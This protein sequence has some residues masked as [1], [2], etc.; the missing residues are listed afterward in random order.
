MIT[1]STETTQS[2][3][4]AAPAVLDAR[5]VV[6]AFG[7]TQAIAEATIAVAPGEVHALVGENGS[8]KSTLV[9]ILTGVHPPDAGTVVVDG[10]TLD[11]VPGPR[12]ASRHGI[13]TAFQEV[14][15]VPAQTV[16]ENL[17]LGVDGILR[18]RVGREQKRRRGAAILAELLVEP[19]PLDRPVEELSLSVRQACCVARALLR[20]PKVLILDEATSALD[21]AT[22]DRLF[23]VIRRRCSAGCSVIFISHRMDEVDEI[24]DRVTVMRAGRTVAT[25]ERGQARTEDLV[26]LMT[27]SG[28]LVPDEVTRRSSAGG[29]VVL[30]ARDARLRAG[31]APLG[32]TLRAG[33]IVGLAGLDGHGQDRFL[34]GLGGFGVA[35]GEILS[36]DAQAGRPISTVADAAACGIA[37]LPR[38]RRGEALFESLSILR[39]FAV[40]TLPADRRAGL[41]ADR[42]TV[43]RFLPFVERLGIK[44]GRVE[45]PIRSLSG[46][47][48][49]KVVLARWLAA[50]PRILLLNDPTR[51]IDLGAKRDLYGLLRELADDGMAVVMLSTEVDEHVELMDRVLV[52]REHELSAELTRAQLSRQTLVS[53]FFRS[54]ATAHA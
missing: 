10:T 5:G 53:A 46:G 31:G 30:R 23:D 50:G 7:A 33:E 12:G 27:G 21:I 38:E 22:R 37:Y 52:F 45:D 36:G 42:R 48:Q 54:G 40:A 39:N 8:G 51:G 24:A 20:D 14:L 32:F 9:K 4:A 25:L 49:Q 41:V 35:G 17:W 16:G 3:G 15:V 13:V 6:K 44:L 47:N 43:Q 29:A 1:S 11:R 2:T 28:H 19:P 26:R 34:R 18:H